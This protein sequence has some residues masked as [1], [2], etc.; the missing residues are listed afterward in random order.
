MLTK[1]EYWES[2]MVSGRRS[3]IAKDESIRGEQ[4]LKGSQ[5]SWLRNHEPRGR[6]TMSV[7]WIAAPNM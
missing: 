3:T 7:I 6:A 5:R 1:G 4:N 2:V